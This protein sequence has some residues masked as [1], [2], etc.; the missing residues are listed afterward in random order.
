MAD[1]W[2]GS[3]P[4]TTSAASPYS[5][6]RLSP[7]YLTQGTHAIEVV[8]V[9]G[10]DAPLEGTTVTL[11][12]LSMQPRYPDEHMLSPA[13][14]GAVDPGA[15]VLRGQGAITASWQWYGHNFS[16]YQ[17]RVLGSTDGPENFSVEVSV[18]NQV[19]G[20]TTLSQDGRLP[21][22]LT[23]ELANGAT[24]TMTLRP[25]G[26]ADGRTAIITLVDFEGYRGPPIFSATSMHWAKG[27]NRAVQS[28]GGTIHLPAR[29]RLTRTVTISTA[30]VYT[31]IARVRRRDI[32]GGAATLHLD[33]DGWDVGEVAVQP[34]PDWTEETLTTYLPVGAHDLQFWW[35]AGM[36]NESLDMMYFIVQ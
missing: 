4:S 28:E 25:L 10:V 2:T 35:D 19:V 13:R 11:M 12:T 20:V 22:P 7:V 6:V 3:Y 5:S 30:K 15:A 26:L 21:E 29:V 23:V 9:A 16:F 14:F 36:T 34:T 27:D 33:A 17:F 24:H 31:I 32:E 18:D 8:R 1:D